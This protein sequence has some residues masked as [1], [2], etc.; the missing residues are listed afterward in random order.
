[1]C[2][3]TYLHTLLQHTHTC[4][5]NS[6]THRNTYTQAHTYV[7]HEQIFSL[8]CSM[9]CVGLYIC[10]QLHFKT[11]LGTEDSEKAPPMDIYDGFFKEETYQQDKNRFRRSIETI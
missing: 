8:L 5:Y 9:T 7:R 4:I 10:R 1:M 3:G 6:C 11:K 2:K